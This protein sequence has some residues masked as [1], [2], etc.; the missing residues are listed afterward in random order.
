[1]PCVPGH[2]GRP[3]HLRL[4]ESQRSPFVRRVS[5][6]IEGSKK[7]TGNEFY[8]SIEIHAERGLTQGQLIDQ[9]IY[10]DVNF[11]CIVLCSKR[12]Q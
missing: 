3:S 6:V 8:Q 2:Y 12:P 10:K 7:K 5:P 11:H 9:E 4:R 1:M